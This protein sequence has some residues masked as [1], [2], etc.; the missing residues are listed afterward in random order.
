MALCLCLHRLVYQRRCPRLRSNAA[1]TL[2]IGRTRRQFFRTRQRFFARR[3][4]PLNRFLAV[5]TAVHQC[6]LV[7]WQTVSKQG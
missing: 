5:S 3:C 1:D 2:N 6:N 7:I 4:R